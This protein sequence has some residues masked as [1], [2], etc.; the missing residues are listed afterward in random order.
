MAIQIDAIIQSG[1]RVNQPCLFG[2]EGELPGERSECGE[3][4]H[5]VGAEGGGEWDDLGKWDAKDSRLVRQ[6]RGRRALLLQDVFSVRLISRGPKRT[7]NQK[8]R[9][10]GTPDAGGRGASRTRTPTNVY[11][12]KKEQLPFLVLVVPKKKK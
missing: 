8:C 4:S 3:G 5:R 10:K 1:T 7:R 2:G 6:G 9:K 12:N 11:R